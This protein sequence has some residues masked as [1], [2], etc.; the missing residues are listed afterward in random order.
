MIPNE[1]LC[2]LTNRC[3]NV[4]VNES[5]EYLE[6]IQDCCEDLFPKVSCA[7]VLL[8]AASF[9]SNIHCGVS[10]KAHRKRRAC[11]ADG[12]EMCC[13]HST[14][15]QTTGLQLPT[16]VFSFNDSGLT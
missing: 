12:R 5:G 4:P 10:R 15:E 3:S 8:S 13:V 2:W 11:L 14:S 9:S 7:L 1:K 6:T 16:L